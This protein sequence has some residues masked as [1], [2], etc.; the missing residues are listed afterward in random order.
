MAAIL[1]YDGTCG[2]CHGLVRWV[3]MRDSSRA[4]QFAP[5]QGE[6]FNALVPS[7]RPADLPDSVVL[8]DDSGALHVR[9]DAVICI[10]EGLGR[11]RTAAVLRALPK[12]LRDWGYSLIAKVRYGIFGRKRE[13]C[14]LV[15]TELR[16][17]FLP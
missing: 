9:C 7:I 10:L 13:S 12:A 17:R 15:P 16:N 11:R 6:T 14:P 5:L 4:F 2:L 1:F 8:R 3:V